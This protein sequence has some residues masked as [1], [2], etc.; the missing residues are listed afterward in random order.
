MVPRISH[1]GANAML[2]VSMAAARAAAPR[3][4]HMPLYAY[5]GST[6]ARRCRCQ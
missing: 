6:N 4:L 1:L 3:A 2:G 5:L